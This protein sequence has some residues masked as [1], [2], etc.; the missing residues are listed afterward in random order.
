MITP[1]LIFEIS[2]VITSFGFSTTALDISES[3]IKIAK[4]KS[5]NM[6]LSVT[7]Y[8]KPA[9]TFLTF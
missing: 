5:N 4:E 1:P 9:C 2:P 6:P 7:K 8:I 3:A